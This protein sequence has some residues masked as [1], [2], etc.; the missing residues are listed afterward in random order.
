MFTVQLAVFLASE[1]SSF[2][3]GAEFIADGGE[4]AGMIRQLDAPE[5]WAVTEER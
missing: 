4:L 3:T 1:E 5:D 2:S